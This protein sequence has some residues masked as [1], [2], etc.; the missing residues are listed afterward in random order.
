MNVICAC[1]LAR[2]AS[3]GIVT[4]AVD[5]GVMGG[6]VGPMVVFF[7]TDLDEVDMTCVMAA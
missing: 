2:V 4:G 3:D 6:G 1:V 7:H 5:V